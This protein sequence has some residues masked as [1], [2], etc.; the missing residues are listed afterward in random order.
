MGLLAVG[1]KPGD[2]TREGEALR[3]ALAFV[4]RP[5]RQDKDGYFGR[6]DG[7]RMYGH[8]IIC[9]MLGEIDRRR[10]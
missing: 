7:S 9:L 8:G 3:R 10:W 6:A 4:L 5:D 2:Q 1:H